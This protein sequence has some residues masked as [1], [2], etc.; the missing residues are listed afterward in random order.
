MINPITQIA[1]KNNLKEN[2]PIIDL[3]KKEFVTYTK[4]KDFKKSMD[5]LRKILEGSMAG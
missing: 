5:K 1:E 2:T 3:E 4:A